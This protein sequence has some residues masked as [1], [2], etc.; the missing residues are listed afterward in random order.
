MAKNTCLYE[1]ATILFSGRSVSR[2]NLTDVLG[3]IQTPRCSR[4]QLNFYAK[5]LIKHC[6][7][8]QLFPRQRVY[9]QRLSPNH[10]SFPIVHPHTATFRHRSNVSYWH[11]WQSSIP[12]LQPRKNIGMS[13]LHT[14][15]RIRCATASGWVAV[16]SWSMWHSRPFFVYFYFYSL[17]LQI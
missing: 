15:D 6:A 16:E 7:G 5:R 11:F 2:T 8:G 4:G 13:R 1:K 17:N 3:V 9:K 12:P 14:R 10:H